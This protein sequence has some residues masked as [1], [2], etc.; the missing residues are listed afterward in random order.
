MIVSGFIVQPIR[1][2]ILVIA[3]TYIK[4]AKSWER[5]ACVMI[6]ESK[7]LKYLS[8]SLIHLLQL[9]ELVPLF[10]SLQVYLTKVEQIN[11]QAGEKKHY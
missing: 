7:I 6:D 3:A 9:L 4:N 11:V 2:Y 10:Q 1:N 5:V 8:A